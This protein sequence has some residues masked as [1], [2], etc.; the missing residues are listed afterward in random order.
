MT[1]AAGNGHEEVCHA[2]IAGSADVRAQVGALEAGN[3]CPEEDGG[4]WW[5]MVD[6]PLGRLNVA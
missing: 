5:R 4:G 2:L 1:Y 3:Q 6:E